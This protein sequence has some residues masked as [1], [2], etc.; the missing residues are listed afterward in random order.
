MER[1]LLARHRFNRGT[2]LKAWAAS[3]LRNRFLDSWR[4]DNAARSSTRDL[5]AESPI[6]CQRGPLDLLSFDDVEDALSTLSG[7]DRNIF[8]AFYLQHRSYDDISRELHIPVGTT[9]TRI[10]RAKLKL[11]RALERT[12]DRRAKAPTEP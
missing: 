4:H 12:Y 2:N 8:T 6:E 5:T 7:A 1:A 3:I 10:Y 9:G 11:R